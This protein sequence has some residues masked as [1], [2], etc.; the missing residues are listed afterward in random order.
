MNSCSD[1]NSFEYAIWR[2]YD[3]SFEFVE[4][5]VNLFFS[6]YW[7]SETIDCFTRRCAVVFFW[8]CANDL[9]TIKLKIFD[10]Q[11]LCFF[12]QKHHEHYHMIS[13]RRW[14][15][16]MC[17]QINVQ[18][19]STCDHYIWL[20]VWAWKTMI[21]IA[22]VRVVEDCYR[23]EH[24]RDVN[25]KFLILFSLFARSM[26]IAKRWLELRCLYYVQRV[27]VDATRR[28]VFEVNRF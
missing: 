25:S 15:S 18:K 3:Y 8:S 5:S 17:D 16:L 24:V 13:S 9:S 21:Y 6:Y 11:S 10:S 27:R 22:F 1:R 14:R 20:I 4:W 19:E 12:A 23:E 7:R 28:I 26:H 2:Q